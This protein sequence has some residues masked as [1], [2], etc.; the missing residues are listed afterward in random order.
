M[1][2]NLKLKYYFSFHLWL[3]LI[4]A[5]L[6]CCALY[7]FDIRSRLA[8]IDSVNRL[9]LVIEQCSAY[10][11]SFSGKITLDPLGLKCTK[12]D[13]NMI[14]RPVE[15]SGVTAPKVESEY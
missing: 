8:N 2:E 4:C 1:D 12:P 6:V 9:Q 7:L 14:S 15:K 13:P 10:D 3:M 11:G 5:V